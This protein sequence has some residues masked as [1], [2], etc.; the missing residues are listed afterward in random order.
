M[1][2][3]FTLRDVSELLN[4]PQHQITYALITKRVPEVQQANGRRIFLMEDIK[5]LA[6]HLNLDVHLDDQ[7]EV[8]D[9]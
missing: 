8:G 3:L 6:N 5:R 2:K 7:R 9:V 4:V 1:Q